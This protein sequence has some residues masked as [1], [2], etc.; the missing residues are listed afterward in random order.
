MRRLKAH[1]RSFIAAA[2]GVE[3]SLRG[4]DPANAYRVNCSAH[5]VTVAVQ[6][7]RGAVDNDVRAKRKRLLEIRT[8]ES[9]I[10]RQQSAV[11]MRNI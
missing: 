9:V 1:Q 6:V 10:N 8:H 4:S 5:A 2:I 7:F 11:L 3:D